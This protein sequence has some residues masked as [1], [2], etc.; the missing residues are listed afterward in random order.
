MARAA[1]RR[2]GPAALVGVALVFGALS[3]GYAWFVARHLRTDARET[4]RM[5]GQVFAGLNDP[6]DG[7]AADA[8]LALADEV[9]R[10]G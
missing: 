6:R 7:A 3:V 9:R 2:A 10:L 1:L 8:L 5:L 4:S